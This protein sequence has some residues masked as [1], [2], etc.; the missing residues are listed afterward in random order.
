MTDTQRRAALIMG[1]GRSGRAAAAFLKRRGA[2][3]RVV[4]RADT[5]ELRA[6]LATD[7]IPGRLG[8]Y[9]QEDLDGV[10]LVVVSPGVPWVCDAMATHDA[11]SKFRTA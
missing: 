6:A 11:S 5:P 1:Y 2:T 4:D 9:A 10:D 3:V 7:G 8:Q